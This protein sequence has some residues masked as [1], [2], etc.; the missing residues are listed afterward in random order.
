MADTASAIGTA[1]A[2]VGSVRAS[3]DERALD[4][5]L[6]VDAT[7]ASV[8]GTTDDGH[9]TVDGLVLPTEEE[10]STLRRVAGRM[11]TTAYYLCAVEFA[12]RASY[13]GCNQVYKNFIRAPL[14]PDGPG[15]GAAA[16]GSDYTAGALDQGTVVATAMTEAFKFLAYALPVYFAWLADTKYGRFKMICWGVAICGIA[17]TI[18][19]ISALPPVLQSGH[20]IGPFAFSL[21]L[22]A[23]GAAQFKPN[24]SPTLM[25]QNPHKIAHIITD[26]KSGERIIVDPEESINSVML[27]FYLLINLGSTFGIA[28]S[29]LA[30]LV[31]YWAAYLIPTILYLLL[32]P[33]LFYLNP[34]LVKQ[35]PGG[36]D[37]VNVFKVLGDI[38]AHGGL[39]SIGRK[40]FWEAGK[41]SVLRA[42][43]ST[44][45]FSYDDQFVNDVRRTFQACGIFLF[46]PIWQINDTGLGAAAN[47]L[48]AGMDTKGLP[49]DLLD[50]L[51]AVS[52]V[53]MVP[54]MN[55]IVYP[56]LRKRGIRWGA[57]SRMT[58][59][60]ALGTIGSVGY[61]VLQYYVYRTSP[62]GWRATTCAKIVPEGA[63][64]LSTVS[65][66]LYS[67]PVVLGAVSEIFVNVTAYG[68]AYSRSPKNMKGLVASVNLFMNAISAAIG[69]A[70]AP[71]IQ[72]PYLVWAF[73]GPTIAGAVSCVAFYLTFR[74]LDH[75]EFVLNTG[76]DDFK[77]ARV[78]GDEERVP[79]DNQVAL[80]EKKA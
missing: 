32:P 78:D 47:A 13:Y 2:S 55:H 17:H 67:I 64:S 29:Y 69:L 12:E 63:E 35:P 39:K 4:E 80:E 20:A 14:P 33:L 16:P 9:E 61:A 77:P 5:K 21:Y 18:M 57:I 8:R 40:G 10:K 27:W 42:A 49:N 72:D 75:E 22:L 3:V 73:A 53:V 28:T 66:G 37:L 25:D 15:T 76:F 7:A 31:G 26:A 34:R 36:S 44:K 58:F 70:T 52:I 74:H 79:A 41:P 65:Y 62:C 24:I 51:N 46:I 54:V 38:F 45:T 56:F 1:L 59:G 71:A 11:P 68:I 30:K 23:I 43:G 19:I 48:T 6:G 60:F 50:N